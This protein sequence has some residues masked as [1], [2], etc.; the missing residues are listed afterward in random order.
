MPR[1]IDAYTYARASLCTRTRRCDPIQ[2]Q[3]R[4]SMQEIVAGFSDAFLIF[5]NCVYWAI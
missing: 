2:T 5:V 1:V 4:N 3:L